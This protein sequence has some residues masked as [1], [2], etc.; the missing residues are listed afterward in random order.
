MA[1]KRITTTVVFLTPPDE[2]SDDA[3]DLLNKT[4][5]QIARTF[6]PVN[7][8]VPITK[9]VH[10]EGVQIFARPRQMKLFG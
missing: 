3:I 5:E 2:I 10:L 1:N 9:Q 6:T 8:G 4:L 7:A